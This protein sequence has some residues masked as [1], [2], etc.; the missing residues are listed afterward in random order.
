MRFD[1]DTEY[2]KR[3]LKAG[4][5]LALLSLALLQFSL[6]SHQYDH[7]ADHLAESCDVCVQL[8]RLDDS[9]SGHAKP[10][11]EPAAPR[12]HEP[13][14]PGKEIGTVPVRPYLSR[15]PPQL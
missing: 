13:G 15:A 1:R 4:S 6:A 11:V 14:L 2:A 8:E 9:A 5:W 3:R 7:A 10:P 12:A